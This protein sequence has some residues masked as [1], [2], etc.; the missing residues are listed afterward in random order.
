MGCGCS[1]ANEG[2]GLSPSDIKDAAQEI[3]DRHTEAFADDFDKALEPKLKE[4]GAKDITDE[5][6]VPYDKACKARLELY[7]GKFTERADGLNQ[8]I[9]ESM[10]W[11]LLPAVAKSLPDKE[12]VAKLTWKAA[13]SVID[14]TIEGAV[15]SVKKD[16]QEPPFLDKRLKALMKNIFNTH[17]D[18]YMP[19]Y[20]AHEAELLK[21]KGKSKQDMSKEE[22]EAFMKEATGTADTKETTEAIIAECKEKIEPAVQ[23]KLDSRKIGGLKAKGIMMGVGVAS[24]KG[25]A[26]AIKAALKKV[27]VKDMQDYKAEQAAK[28]GKEPPVFKEIVVGAEIDDAAKSAIESAKN[29]SGAAILHLDEDFENILLEKSV[30]GI[31]EVEVED[32][33][34]RFVI[35][36]VG[37]QAVAAAVIG[38]KAGTKNTFIY[39]QF[40]R[41]IPEAHG[42]AKKVVVKKADEIEKAASAK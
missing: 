4:L 39:T 17:V 33:D 31:G 25:G 19:K 6:S 21:T 22:R 36:Q 9:K 28:E 11:E 20:H 10:E 16:V 23:T 30:G 42:I 38:G 35:A 1:T 29:G 26:G 15:N 24:K 18:A 32:T 14:K 34:A 40:N 2:G 37:G 13:N 5:D 8:V 7:N 41:I 12:F 27:V 3:C